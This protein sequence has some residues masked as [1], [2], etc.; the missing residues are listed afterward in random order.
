MKNR[1]KCGHAACSSRDEKDLRRSLCLVCPALAFAAVI[2]LT[3]C[4]FLN[5]HHEQALDCEKVDRQMV[6][7][8]ERLQLNAE[9]EALVRP[10]IA[11]QLKQRRDVLRDGRD[12][13]RDPRSALLAIEASVDLMLADV[14]T[15][16]QMEAYRDM[17]R[18]ELLRWRDRMIEEREAFR[19]DHGEIDRSG[20]P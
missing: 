9:Q 16:E 3:S 7:L 12:G 8:R 11:E 13:R 20:R 18:E 10:I 5:R 1:E 6:R 2:F 19:P 15:P 4:G 14:L 17:R